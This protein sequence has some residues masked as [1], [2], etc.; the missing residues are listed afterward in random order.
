M[1][2]S[3]GT[4]STAGPRLL[5]EF[6]A[7]SGVDSRRLAREASLDA[8]QLADPAGRVETRLATDLWNRAAAA[9]DDPLFGVHFGRD[10]Q[11]SRLGLFDYLFLTANTLE[12]AFDTVI[13]NVS[14]ASTGGAYQQARHGSRVV[15]ERVLSD[16]PDYRHAEAFVLGWQLT[17]ARH[18]TGRPIRPSHVGLA[19]PAPKQ[20]RGLAE[21]LGVADIDFGCS[22]T[23][24][25]LTRG[26]LDL[27]LLSADPML[28]AVL[29]RHAEQ[30]R[31]A[32]DSWPHQVRA[33]LA[34]G[35]TGRIV[36]LETAA[37]Q[38]AVSPRTLQQHLHEAETSWRVEVEAVRDY[39]AVDL[40]RNSQLPVTAIANQLGYSD[41]RAFRR[42]FHRRHSRSPHE[43]RHDT[44]A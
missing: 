34:D 33:F 21:A 8:E 39:L 14:V 11:P 29:R 1:I 28:A 10:H 5:L 20:H 13:R 37:R 3:L 24:I 16:G 27:P 18:A 44:S 4:V 23:T 2:V 41:A 32:A 12:D 22:A 7:R 35:F 42:A 9:V 38:M 15:V 19:Q 31:P 6:V 17:M 40:L 30:R 26:D 43:Y 36:T 25:T